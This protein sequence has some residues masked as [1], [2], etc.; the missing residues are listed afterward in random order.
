MAPRLLLMLVVVLLVG[1][2]VVPELLIS[3]ERLHQKS[4][5]AFQNVIFTRQ[6]EY[7]MELNGR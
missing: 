4:D 2:F 5:G 6:S 1:S 3:L 7:G